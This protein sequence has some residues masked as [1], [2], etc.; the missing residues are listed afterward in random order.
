MI[1]CFDPYL[2]GISGNM[3]VGA[4]LS[5]DEANE[6]EIIK[7]AKNVSPKFKVKI[8]RIRKNGFLATHVETLG[9][10][11]LTPEELK[12]YLKSLKLSKKAMDFSLKT[13]NTIIK[14]EKEIHGNELKLHLHELGSTD[15]VFDIAATAFLADKLG[16]FGKGAAVV[17]TP[18]RVGTGRIKTEHGYIQNPAP[19][20]LEIARAY[21]IPIEFSNIKKEIATPTGVA[22]LANLVNSFI[23]EIPPVKIKNIGYGA[24][25]FSLSFPN[26]LRVILCES[27][28]KGEYISVI[29]TN[30]D[31]ISGEIL[32]YTIEKLYREGAL[33]VQVLHGITKKNRPSFIIS[34]ITKLGDEE[35][36]AKILMYE[37]GT[38]GVRIKR[39]QKR[40]TFDREIKTITVNISGRK[41]KVRIKI[42]YDSDGKPVNF[43]PE[44][45]D[46]KKIAEEFGISIK[47]VEKS[48]PSE[49]CRSS[50]D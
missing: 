17:S 28:L 9:D 30:V 31:D 10:E 15:T 3:I 34:V 14:A 37:T 50:C 48:L 7:L 42:A 11:K 44:Y 49:L 12:K 23:F 6:E 16:F 27:E 39:M 45:E 38:L 1:V 47:R 43:K 32:G 13:L 25:S 29:E 35:R 22:I 8:R 24:G 36:L 41:R 20:T 19:V 33:D 26:I 40:F 2:A 46:L 18:V 21:K 4:L 5:L